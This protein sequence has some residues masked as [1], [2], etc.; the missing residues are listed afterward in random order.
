MRMTDGISSSLSSHRPGNKGLI[1][2]AEAPTRKRRWVFFLRGGGVGG[3]QRGT[4]RGPAVK[5]KKKSPVSPPD[6]SPDGVPHVEAV[7]RLGAAGAPSGQ[8]HQRRQPVGDMHELAA[9][10]PRP[11]QQRAGHERD[12]PDP[13]FPQRPLPP[14]QRPVAAAG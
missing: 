10:A 9:D 3:S 13:A 2:G 6:D 8:T 1:E 12:S 7:Q 14:S 4:A 11:L 5:K